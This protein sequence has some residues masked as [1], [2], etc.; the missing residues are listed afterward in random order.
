MRRGGLNG[1]ALGS[2]FSHSEC[3]EIGHDL[4]ESQRLKKPLLARKASQ[5]VQPDPLGFWCGVFAHGRNLTT[6][7]TTVPRIGAR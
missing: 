2:A 6:D 4:A 5:H 1:R 7:I 3:R